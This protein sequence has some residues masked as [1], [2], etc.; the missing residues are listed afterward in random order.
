MS[1]EDFRQ[2]FGEYWPYLIVLIVGFLPTEIWRWLAVMLAKDLREDSDLLLWVRLVASTL[3]AAV[4][5]KMV[6]APAGVLA[7]VPLWGRI[8]SVFGAAGALFLFRR[9]V[10]AAV[11]AGEALLIGSWFIAR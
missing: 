10:V 11:L 3:L 8:F 9:S 1:V 2:L 5:A 7:T 4:V 6:A